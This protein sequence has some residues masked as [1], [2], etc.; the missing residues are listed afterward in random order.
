MTEELVPAAFRLWTYLAANPLA[1][2]VATLAA[3]AA[4]EALWRWAGRPDLMNPVL[5]AI[6][7]VAA[8]LWLTGVPYP[9][10]FE[11]AQFIHVM[12]GP[13]TV[14]LAV[15][16]WRAAPVIRRA[17]LPVAGALAMGSVAASAGAMALAAA[18]GASDALLA[19]VAAK[20]VTTPVAMALSDRLGGLPGLTAALVIT[21]GVV[22]A[23]FGGL[24]FGLLR[25]TDPRAQGF[26]MGVACHGIGL[27]WALRRS[28]EAGA[29][30]S[31]GMALN[32][33]LTALV[34]PLAAAWVF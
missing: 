2:V 16:L 24:L 19:T 5:A 25:L 13:A 9:A 31:L 14:A 20:S 32:A 22:G 18:F 3:Y 4:A 28:P 12:L 10:Y 34:L 23:T 6:A 8:G 29:F 21:T 30:A 27:A 7:L 15:P 1:G 17:A 33:L 11:G 26:A